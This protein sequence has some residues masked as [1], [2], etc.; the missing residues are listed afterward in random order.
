MGKIGVSASTLPYIDRGLLSDINDPTEGIPRL[1]R[2]EIEDAEER[3][4]SERKPPERNA[5]F[6]TIP[7]DEWAYREG[8]HDG[9]RKI[10]KKLQQI[11]NSGLLDATVTSFNNKDSDKVIKVNYRTIKYKIHKEDDSG[12]GEKVHFET[13][14][15]TP[16]VSINDLKD[17]IP[18]KIDGVA[19]NEQVDKLTGLSIEVDPSPVENIPVVIE[20]VEERENAYY[21]KKYRPV[22]GGC[23]VSSGYLGGTMGHLQLRPGMQFQRSK[24]C[25]LLVTW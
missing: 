12:N 18:D 6:Y 21:Y 7:Y 5:V 24:E 9:A 25:L 17:K 22:L 8:V 20:K 16:Q 1:K 19:G 15:E 23:Q 4:I 10:N 2:L 14:V 3:S 13:E 11:D